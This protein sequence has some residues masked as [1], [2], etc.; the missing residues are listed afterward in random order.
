MGNDIHSNHMVKFLSFLLLLVLFGCQNQNE[1][2]SIEKPIKDVASH[3]I[4]NDSTLDKSKY[5]SEELVGDS[6]LCST[7]SRLVPLYKVVFDTLDRNPLKNIK[8]TNRIKSEKY[9]EDCMRGYEDIYSI[10][11]KLDNGFEIKFIQDNT[12]S[13]SA[14]ITVVNQQLFSVRKLFGEMFSK[15]SE[16]HFHYD[17]GSFYKLS[18]GNILFVEQP[19]SW[20]GR[21]NVFDCYQYFDLKKKEIIQF[22]EKDEFINT[23]K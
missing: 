5:F 6:M 23:L 16:I 17:S 13:K 14:L 2:N 20:C 9:I 19:A 10:K 4:I 3:K 11:L 7:Y 8:I 18:D 22:I 12:D 21:A 15:D 1:K